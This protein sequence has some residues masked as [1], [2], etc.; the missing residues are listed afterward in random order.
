MKQEAPTSISG[1]SMSL[2]QVFLLPLTTSALFSRSTDPVKDSLV[3]YQ[4][5]E[6]DE[7]IAFLRLDG[8]ILDIGS[9]PIPAP[10]YQHQ[11]FLRELEIAFSNPEFQAVVLYVNS[12]GGGIYES[13]EIYQ[14]IESLKAEYNKPFVVYMGRLAASGGYYVSAPADWIVANRNTITGSIG[15]VISS[16]NVAELLERY[17]IKDQTI[18]SGENK[19]ILSPFQELKPEQ[20]AIIQSIVDES[21]GYFVDVVAEGRSMDTE[22]VLEVADG[23][24]YSG[25]QAM[26]EG[27]V[28]EIGMLETAFSV[29]AERAGVNNP[30]IYAFRQ[31]QWTLIDRLLSMSPSFDF[32]RDILRHDAEGPRPMYL[33]EW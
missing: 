22:Q 17:G 16:L 11:R 8:M 33:W 13:D 6:E 25:R 10:G 3:V 20:R 23:R 1:G 5:G 28:D 12:P 32:S 2:M 29:A 7:G 31:Q 30:T 26:E 24:I 27:L 14:T 18:A 15:V 21:Y 9:G 19:T 4:Q